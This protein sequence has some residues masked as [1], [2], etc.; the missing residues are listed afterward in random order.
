MIG[1][2]GDK[3]NTILHLIPYHWVYGKIL[4]MLRYYI[5][6]CVSGEVEEERRRHNEAVSKIESD[7]A[8][9]RKSVEK[10]ERELKNTLVE[11][12]KAME[13]LSESRKAMEAEEND[14]KKKKKA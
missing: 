14:L 10:Q 12:Q 7:L 13:K 9:K 8:E 5:E 2:N 11:Y 4:N 3:C 6:Y 1:R